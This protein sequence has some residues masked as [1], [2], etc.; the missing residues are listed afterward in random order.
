M[1]K[2]RACNN[3]LILFKKYSLFGNIVRT[4]YIAYISYHGR[5]STDAKDCF[6]VDKF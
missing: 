2:K 6:S 1:S 5:T 3:E 4:K